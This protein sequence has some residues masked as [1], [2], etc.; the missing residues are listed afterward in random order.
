M[1]D[2]ARLS[3]LATYTSP[4]GAN[5]LG[6][7]DFPKALVASAE[8]W[9]PKGILFGT[10]EINPD[11]SHSEQA[12]L[13]EILDTRIKDKRVLVC[14]GRDDKLVPYHCSE[15]FLQ[16]LKNAASGWYKDGNLYVEDNVYA[17]IG[18]AYSEGMIKDTIRFV[19]DTLSGTSAVDNKFSIKI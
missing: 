15:P 3:K 2:R 19:N 17:G 9:D 7:K 12:L 18:H 5:F 14:S 4:D 8:K 10:S 11:P 6:S 13:R 1:S 16:F